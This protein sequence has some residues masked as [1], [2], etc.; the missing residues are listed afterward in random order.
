MV[1]GA[2]TDTAGLV[3]VSGTPPGQRALIATLRARLAQQQ[4]VVNAYKE[5]GR[6]HV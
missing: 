1:N 6:A 5:I 4:Q 3:T 2:E